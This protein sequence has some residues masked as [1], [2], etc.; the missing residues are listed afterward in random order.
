MVPHQRSRCGAAAVL[1]LAVFACGV[2][3]RE[4]R[5]PRDPKERIDVVLAS[6]RPPTDSE[7]TIEREHAGKVALGKLGAASGQ[8]FA[9]QVL[10][11]GLPALEST[12]QFLKF[13]VGERA[14]DSNDPRYEDI[15]RDQTVSVENGVWVFRFHIK[16]K[17]FGAVNRPPSA[18][19]LIVEDFGAI[20]RHPSEHGVGVYVALSQRALP[21]DLDGALK[22]EADEVL[23]SIEFSSAPTR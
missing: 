21:Q 6:V 13:A 5:V 10:L 20:F 1:A 9:G 11:T 8:S 4:K 18:P 15:V 7:W 17:D 12:E 14:L 19:Y 23:G 16:Y 2:A 22:Q 3:P